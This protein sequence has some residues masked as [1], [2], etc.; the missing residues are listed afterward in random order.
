[1]VQLCRKGEKMKKI[2][3]CLMTFIMPLVL[4]S[5][6]VEFHWIENNEYK[7]V[8]LPERIGIPVLVGL[9]VFILF[10][11]CFAEMYYL[12]HRKF[13][14]PKCGAEISPHWYE[15]SALLHQNNRSV[16]KCPDCKRKGFCD[17]IGKM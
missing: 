8:F 9:I 11:I 5:C 2:Y 4:A 16:M 13:R 15:F 7:R 17:L 6:Q 10:V 12:T 14:C 3:F 1:M